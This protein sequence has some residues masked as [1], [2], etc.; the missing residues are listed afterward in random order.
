MKVNKLT[1]QNFRNIKNS[2]FLPNQE[3]NVICGEN[4]QGKTNLIEAIWLFTGAKSFR[5][6][7]DFELVEFNE[8]AA[9]LKL[10]FT[11]K[12]IEKDAEIVIDQKRNA[13][14]NGKKLPSASRFSGEFCAIIFSPDD[15]M[16]VNGSPAERRRFLDIAISQVYPNY[17]SNLRKYTRAVS[18]RNAILKEIKNGNKMVSMLSF[19]E[20]EIAQNGE[21]IIKYRT[22]YI[23]LIKPFLKETY[24][25]ISESREEFDIEYNFSC[26]KGYLREALIK[27]REK[28]IFSCTTSVGPHRD[29]LLFK[30]NGN[31]VKEFGSQGQKRSVALSLK[32][33]QAEVLKSVTGEIP[34]ALLDDV[35]S[36]LDPNRQD[37]VLNHIK[38]WQVFI[39]CCDPSNTKNL[40]EGKI[41]SIK[42]GRIEE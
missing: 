38:G 4:A 27:S 22:K 30:I 23:E 32:L 35:M 15:I 10:S 14:L 17:V 42:D 7:K 16:L 18:Q 26:E 37:Y 8:N 29:D 36:E 6:N 2:V 1:L 34:V 24:K 33:S 20:E 12:G 21:E 31:S 40:N 28:D 5:G 41:F 9:K 25:G 39:T 11:A 19:F 13:Y 3:M